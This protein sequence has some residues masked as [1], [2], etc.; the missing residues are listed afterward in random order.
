MEYDREGKRTYFHLEVVE[1]NDEG[2]RSL[3]SWD[4]DHVFTFFRNLSQIQQERSFSI[5]NKT[6]RVVSKLVRFTWF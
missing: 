2:F 1:I 5:E 6:L 4:P 3:G